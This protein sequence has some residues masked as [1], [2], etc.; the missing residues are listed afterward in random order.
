MVAENFILQTW[1]E[2]LIIF[3]HNFRI[4]RQKPTKKTVHDLRVSVKRI[5][6]LLRL[7][8]KITGET[9]KEQFAPVKALFILSGKQRDFEMSLFILSK[10]HRKENLASPLFKNYLQKN[11]AMTRQWTKK[12]AMEFN[13]DP[14]QLLTSSMNS[15]L[16]ALTNEEL[17]M[18]IKKITEDA[19][20]TVGLLAS[21]LNK[22]AHEI[23]KLLKDIYY[24]LIVCPYN[25][26]NDYIEIKSL[27]KILHNLGER[28]DNFI[29]HK[30]LKYFKKEYLVKKSKEAETVKLLEKEASEVQNE[31]LS[32]VSKNLCSIFNMK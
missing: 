14:L 10:F 30:K 1:N 17:I 4:V 2:Q 31:L 32:Q 13:D 27:D 21:D 28:Q 9:W 24:W 5:R 29:F 6:S 23:R 12:A 8:E 20:K 7:R 3:L 16:S 18:K 26:V 25:P 22:N 11:K 15:S 19:L